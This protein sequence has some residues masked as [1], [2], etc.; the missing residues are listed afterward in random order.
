MVAC[1]FAS[2][3]CADRR[4][5]LLTTE[6]SR[7]WRARHEVRSWAVRYHGIQFVLGG[8]LREIDR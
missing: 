5:T 3:V 4:W 2:P 8:G 1:V 6:G 7:R